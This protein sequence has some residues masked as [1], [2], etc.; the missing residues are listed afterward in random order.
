MFSVFL[1]LAYFSFAAILPESFSRCNGTYSTTDS[2]G[3]ITSDSSPLSLNSSYL[4][5]VTCFFLISSSNPAARIK[6][7]FEYSITECGY[8]FLK[9]HDG[10][11][12]NSS[13]VARLTGRRTYA[14][15]PKVLLNQVPIKAPDVFIS[16]GNSL[17]VEFVSDLYVNTTG[18]RAQYTIIGISV[19]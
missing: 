6:L 19:C 3:I 14:N 5:D 13:V 4:D 18:F 7:S 16:S 9:V 1:L 8:D 12:L 11:S 17:F 15:S 10:E 2:S